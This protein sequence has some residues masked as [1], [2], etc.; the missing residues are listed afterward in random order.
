M[1]QVLTVRIHPVRESSCENIV[2]QLTFG[3]VGDPK[4]GQSNLPMITILTMKIHNT[5][6]PKFGIAA[7]WL[8]CNEIPIL[9]QEVQACM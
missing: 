5:N 6:G 8:L 7:A 4:K 9:L 3:Q 1:Y 2:K